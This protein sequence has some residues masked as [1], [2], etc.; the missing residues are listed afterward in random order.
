MTFRDP[1]QNE[2]SMFYGFSSSSNRSGMLD[3]FEMQDVN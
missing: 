2:F 3:W 1:L